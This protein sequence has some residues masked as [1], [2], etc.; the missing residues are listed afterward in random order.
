MKYSQ[1]S[2]YKGSMSKGGQKEAGHDQ[3]T[4]HACM[5]VS[6]QTHLFEQWMHVNKISRKNNMRRLM[7]SKPHGIISRG[8]RTIQ[9][10]AFAL[11]KHLHTRPSPNTSTDVHGMST[12]GLSSDSPSAG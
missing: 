1:L 12:I 10:S 6:E 7:C 11:E 4:A 3:N 2:D 9:N 8:Y 5:D